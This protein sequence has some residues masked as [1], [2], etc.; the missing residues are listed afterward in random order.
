MSSDRIDSH[1]EESS[2]PVVR[3]RERGRSPLVS[4]RD[5]TPLDLAGDEN[6]VDALRRCEHAFNEDVLPPRARLEEPRE[7]YA[8]TN[9]G[10]LPR[11]REQAPCKQSLPP[12]G[13]ANGVAHDARSPPTGRH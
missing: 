4:A 1:L 13:T 2:Q 9:M 12:Y 10:C 5:G 3:L 7:F 6:L 8:A 11:S